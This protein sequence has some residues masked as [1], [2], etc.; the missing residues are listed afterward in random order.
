[1]GSRKGRGHKSSISEGGGKRRSSA[2]ADDA[3][4]RVSKS[5]A[6]QDGGRVRDD[7]APLSKPTSAP[8]DAPPLPQ[9]EDIPAGSNPFPPPPPASSSTEQP[10]DAAAI[11]SQDL[12]PL[13]SPPEQPGDVAVVSNEVPPSVVPSSEQPHDDA[14]AANRGPPPPVVSPPQQPED[15]AAVSNLVSPQ[16]MPAAQQPAD[17][18]AI[19]THSRPLDATSPKSCEGDLAV[20]GPDFLPALPVPPVPVASLAKKESGRSCEPDLSSSDIGD[21]ALCPYARTLDRD[22]VRFPPKIATVHCNCVESLCGD[23]GDFRGHDVKEKL[24]VNYPAQRRNSSV[25]VTTACICVATTRTLARALALAWPEEEEDHRAQRAAMSTQEPPKDRSKGSRKGRGHKSSISE[26][27]GKRRS[28]APADDAGLSVSKSDAAQDGRRVRD[29]VAHLSKPTSAP[30]DAPPLPQ[31]EDVPAGSN[32]FPP[33]PPASSSTERPKDVAAVSV[34]DLAPLASPPEQP[35]DVTVVSNEVPPPAV[36]SFE[37]PHDDAMAA[38]QG[39]PPQ[40]VSPPQQPEDVAAVSN[41]VSPQAM[42]AAQQPADVS[43]ISVHSRPLDATSAKSC[44]GEPAVP[45]PNFLP[46]LPV[47]PVPELTPPPQGFAKWPHW[48]DAKTAAALTGF[49]LIAA[50]VLTTVL[51]AGQIKGGGSWLCMTLD[52]AA[53]RNLL[54]AVL[55]DSVDPC[56]DFDAFVC[57]RHQTPSATA[58]GVDV[59]TSTLSS[60]RRHWLDGFEKLLEDGKE[61]L[62]VGNKAAAMYASCLTHKPAN[63][64]AVE[65]F[66]VMLKLRSIDQQQQVA[67]VF[68]VLVDVAYNWQ[69]PLWFR[70]AVLPRNAY[71]PSRRVLITRNP[72]IAEWQA[73]LEG[74]N[75]RDEYRKRWSQTEG[76][77]ASDS[78]ILRSYE[79]RRA[80]FRMLL[81]KSASTTDALRRFALGDASNHASFTSDM[82]QLLNQHIRSNENFSKQDLMIF[83]EAHLLEVINAAFARFENSELMQHVL[84]LF[85]DVYGPI[86]D[87]SMLLSHGHD[88]DANKALHRYCSSQVEA[89]YHL[90]VNALF[91]FSR[92]TPLERQSIIELIKGIHQRA[93]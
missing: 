45:G 77:H 25:E 42:P 31:P 58:Y 37:Q 49:V 82:P 20:P 21:R 72:L 63:K 68:G 76:V 7:V 84:W 14:V 27:G 53:H 22:P 81:S 2:P 33:P 5:D 9:P 83:E 24:L 29:D 92:L 12:A 48:L 13:A 17:V 47:P 52:C 67:S 30:P 85:R 16:A 80:I 57:P 3:G 78:V 8:P 74:L 51:H 19:S 79:T 36:P 73:A 87:P 59:S 64:D 75:G 38:N 56:Q 71:H 89:S 26:G 18:S 88:P 90:L 70:V 50:A 46:A 41:L 60:M 28:S 54:D 86:S 39:P 61:F 93:I 4:R 1:M 10:K 55:N 11:S 66:M 6:A 15:V 32:A 65:Q 34:Q 44:E 91:A 43:A 62:A 23:V 69:A 40:V 35:S